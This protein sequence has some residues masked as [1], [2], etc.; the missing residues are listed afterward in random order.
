MLSPRIAPAMF[1]VGLLEGVPEDDILAALED[2]DDADGDGISGRA[3]CPTRPPTRRPDDPDAPTQ[4][5]GRFGWKAPVADGRG[6]ERRRVRRRH[7]HHLD[8]C[9]R[10][11]PA[12]TP[13]PSASPR[14]TAATPS[15]TTS[16]LDQVTFYTR[17]LAVPARRDVGAADTDRGQELFEQ[18]GCASCHAAELRTGPSR[19]R[20]PRPTR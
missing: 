17:T 19:H 4:V 20:R 9:T 11:S 2:P 7:R 18:I 3:R 1:G 12:P 14:P 5:L 13:S 15:S 10:R 16:K 6:A 8:R